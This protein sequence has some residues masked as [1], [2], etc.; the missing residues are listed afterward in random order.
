MPPIEGV[1]AVTQKLSVQIK[2]FKMKVDEV[3]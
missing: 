2:F 1:A 3:L